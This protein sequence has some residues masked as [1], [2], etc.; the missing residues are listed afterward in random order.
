MG[1]CAAKIHPD[2]PS[3]TAIVPAAEEPPRSGTAEP[4]VDENKAA[5]EVPAASE[6]PKWSASRAA[7]ARESRSAL[8]GMSRCVPRSAPIARALRS[9]SAAFCACIFAVSRPREAA[10]S[11]SCAFFKVLATSK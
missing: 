3:E 5:K 2:V 11:A 7:T 10:F 9:V 6:P 4:E 8:S 1:A